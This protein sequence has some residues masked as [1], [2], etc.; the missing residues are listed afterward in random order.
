MKKSPLKTKT[1]LRRGTPLKKSNPK[2][3][4]KAFEENFGE[5]AEFIR[6][7]SCVVFRYGSLP[8]DLNRTDDFDCEG[9]IEAMHTTSRGAGGKKEHLVPICQK[10]HREQHNGPH[11][12]ERKY[13]LNLAMA[14]DLYEILWMLVQTSEAA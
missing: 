5:K 14:A 13:R 6:K 11:S 3:K 12:F 8:D 4:K 2:R 7:Q 1:E 10:H 9:K